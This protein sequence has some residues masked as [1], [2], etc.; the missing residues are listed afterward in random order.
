MWMVLDAHEAIAWQK[1]TS[2]QEIATR[3][4][5]EEFELHDIKYGYF[6]Q[7]NPIRAT[8]IRQELTEQADIARQVVNDAQDEAEQILAE[9]KAN[10]T[11]DLEEHV[12][13]L[14][15]LIDQ[16]EQDAINSIQAQDT[17][18]ESVY[19]FF[20]WLGSL[21]VLIIGSISSYSI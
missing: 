20:T 5:E 2:A 12:S 18:V 10:H 6:A 14:S 19:G 16:A 13:N 7:H 3:R 4:I 8:Q 17:I 1:I 15:A 11:S 21:R 9:Q